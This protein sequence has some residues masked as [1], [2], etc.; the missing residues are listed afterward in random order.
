MGVEGYSGRQRFKAYSR[1][2]GDSERH[3]IRQI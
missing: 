2:G 1:D 3:K